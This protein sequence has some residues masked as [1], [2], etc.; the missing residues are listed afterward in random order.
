MRCAT[1][2][3]GTLLDVI[4]CRESD[5]AGGHW[6]VV[7]GSPAHAAGEGEEFVSLID[8]YRAAYVRADDAGLVPTKR[9]TATKLAAVDDMRVPEL[10]AELSK[11]SLNTS[12]LKAQLVERLKAVIEEEGSSLSSAQAGSQSD[13][14]LTDVTADGDTDAA[15]PAQ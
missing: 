10:R 7:V 6:R 11:R 14:N 4:V 12:G 5:E 2:D 9:S 1:E 8:A 13:V 3:A 15:D